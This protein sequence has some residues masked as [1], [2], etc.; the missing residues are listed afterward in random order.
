MLTME[1]GGYHPIS[2][3][4]AI[5][6]GELRA[7]TKKHPDADPEANTGVMTIALPVLVTGK[8]KRH[9]CTVMVPVGNVLI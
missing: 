2:S 6:S 7:L 3:P 1:D 8:L 5:C 4:R 9:S